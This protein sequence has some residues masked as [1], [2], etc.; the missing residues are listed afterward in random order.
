MQ[1][2]GE[3]LE[4]ARKKKGI[5]IR[6]A[7]EATKIRG[8]YLQKF[9]G[10]QFEIGLT[11]IYTKGFLKGYAN[12]LRLPS[13]RL[14]N[15]YTA[16]RGSDARVRQPSR[17][18]YGRMD[19]GIS[20]TD[21]R[22]EVQPEPQASEPTPRTT[23]QARFQ[24]PRENLPKAPAI[25]PAL[26]FKGGIALVFVL[27]LLA[28]VWIVK[29]LAGPTAPTTSGHAAPASAPE[30]SEAPVAA[31]APTISIVA[32]EAV[33]IKVVRKSDGAELFQGA[34]Q[35]GDKRDYPN[36]P[37]YLTASDLAAV[38]I[39]YKGKAYPTGHSGHDRIQFDFSSR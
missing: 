33:R 2:I 9:E 7:A 23:Q 5:S 24:R 15:D 26:V 4:D 13:D 1:T 6:E 27:V 22:S 36:V 29:S 31:P 18:V 8:E 38:Q 34:L 3:R 37:L 14:L 39:E 28:I 32:S 35:A 11:D 21:E 17:E 16:L 10:N 30:M 25:D 19:L 12:Y 20:S